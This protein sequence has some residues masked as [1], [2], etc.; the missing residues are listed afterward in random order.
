[1]Q[2]E[3]FLVAVQRLKTVDQ[4]QLFAQLQNVF[5]GI[6][7]MPTEE[8]ISAYQA[9][10]FMA[11]SSEES[12][13]FCVHLMRALEVRMDELTREAHGTQWANL[14]SRFNTVKL[15]SRF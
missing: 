9:L 8:V 2:D 12:R 14:L 3:T 5:R 15:N 6:I 10:A 1:M 7:Q 13:S 4:S 11:E